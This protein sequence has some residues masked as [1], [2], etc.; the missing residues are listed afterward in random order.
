MSRFASFTAK[1]TKDYDFRGHPMIEVIDLMNQLFSV[2][3][4]T[5]P[6]MLYHLVAISLNLELPALT[7]MN[8]RELLKRLNPIE[9]LRD[10]FF[11]GRFNFLRFMPTPIV[12]LQQLTLDRALD[13]LHAF[14]QEGQQ[15]AGSPLSKEEKDNARAWILR[16]M[17]GSNLMKQT[18]FVM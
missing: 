10:I 15:K 1:G 14:I 8:K 5:E 3:Y 9:N 7:K 13:Y 4:F 12:G 17:Q 16:L 11:V 2:S 18:G 6:A